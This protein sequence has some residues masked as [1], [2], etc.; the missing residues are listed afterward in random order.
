VAIYASNRIPAVN[1]TSQPKSVAPTWAEIAAKS[2]IPVDT[3]TQP[4]PKKPP[5]PTSPKQSVT[6]SGTPSAVAKQPQEEDGWVT[7]VNGKKQ[8]SLLPTGPQP[9]EKSQTLALASNPPKDKEQTVNHSSP[10]AVSEQTQPQ[11]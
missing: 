11:T 2:Q 6:T 5:A 4:A 1:Q 8:K 9:Q 7:I 10:L 3:K